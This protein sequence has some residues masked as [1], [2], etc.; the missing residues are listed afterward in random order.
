MGI[1]HELHEVVLQR[2]SSQEKSVTSI[3]TKEGLPSLGAEV[4]DVMSFVEDKVVPGFAPEDVLIGENELI[5]SD[6]DMESVL[7]IP[8]FSLLLSFLLSTVVNH[9]FETGKE[10]AELHLPVQHDTRWNDN[11]VR[12]P[13]SFIAGEM[14]EKRDRLDS[15]SETHLIGENSAEE[16]V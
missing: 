3:E 15:L 4:F 16:S 14:S 9:E 7:R 8:T 10:F 1:T 2:S 12:S 11:E 13:L 6:A 5:R